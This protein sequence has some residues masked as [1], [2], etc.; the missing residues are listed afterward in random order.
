[1]PSKAE[2]LSSTV[3]KAAVGALGGL[4]LG[5]IFKLNPIVCAGIGIL[6]TIII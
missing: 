1:M 4:V 2:T 6:A 5:V 3:D